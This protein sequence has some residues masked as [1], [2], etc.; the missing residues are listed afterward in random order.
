MHRI[1]TLIV[2]VALLISLAGC[3]MI[4]FRFDT[5]TQ[6]AVD[7]ITVADF[8][9]SYYND[10][11]IKE[12]DKDFDFEPREPGKKKYYAVGMP[13]LSFVYHRIEEISAFESDDAEFYTVVSGG[14]IDTDDKYGNRIYK[15]VDKSLYDEKGKII[16]MTDELSNVFDSILELE[17]H[18]MFLC[19]IIKDG[20]EYFVYNELNVNW[21]YPCELYYYN[22][23]S[24]SLIMLCQLDG[25]RIIDI[26]IKN[27]NL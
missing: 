24:H 2:A 13:D 1:P 10:V 6:A 16:E 4:S 26:K 19:Q 18:E 12:N 23:E 8:D 3:S 14:I 11:Y 9:I 7:I 17:P 20:D 27:L 5:E 22:K 15:V 21:W 25:E